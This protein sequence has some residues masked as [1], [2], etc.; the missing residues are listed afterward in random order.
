MLCHTVP[1]I[2]KHL[3][4]LQGKSHTNAPR[5]DRGR[6]EPIIRDDEAIN[7]DGMDTYCDDVQAPEEEIPCRLDHRFTIIGNFTGYEEDPQA[8]TMDSKLAGFDPLANQD[9]LFARPAGDL[10]CAV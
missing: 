6:A 10:L 2:K 3:D 4:S 1:T 9:P 5:F 8:R 7:A